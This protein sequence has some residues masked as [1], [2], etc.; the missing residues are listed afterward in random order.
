MIL[1]SSTADFL[2]RFWHFKELEGTVQLLKVEKPKP[3]KDWTPFDW[4]VSSNNDVLMK[5]AQTITI[6]KFYGLKP[7]I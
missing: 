7:L 3:S 1:Y 6:K 5:F 4:S 2:N